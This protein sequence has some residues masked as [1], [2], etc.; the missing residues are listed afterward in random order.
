[1]Y[2]GTVVEQGETQ[3]V[4]RE[5]RHP[6][7]IGL[8]SSA[9]SVRLENPAISEAVDIR[10]EPP[11]PGTQIEGCKFANRCWLRR[12]LGDPPECETQRPDLTKRDD[13]ERA[14]ACHFVSETARFSERLPGWALGNK[15]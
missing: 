6:Y 4:L 3:A 2:A 11:D 10:G 7:T 9:P 15:D 14:V 8:V 5:P 13:D 1:M 12:S